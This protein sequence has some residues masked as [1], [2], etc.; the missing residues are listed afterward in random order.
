MKLVFVITLFFGIISIVKSEFAALVWENDSTCRSDTLEQILDLGLATQ[1]CSLITDEMTQAIGVSIQGFFKADCSSGSPSINLYSDPSCATPYPLMSS[2][3]LPTT[4]SGDQFGYFND[5]F[6]YFTCAD[7]S[8]FIVDVVTS[9]SKFY[10]GQFFN[11][12]D[13]APPTIL[14]SGWKKMRNCVKLHE[15]TTFYIIEKC[16]SENNTFTGALFNDSLCIHEVNQTMPLNYRTG[17]CTADGNSF[18]QSLIQQTGG[19]GLPLPF[20]FTAGGEVSR[21]V[22]CPPKKEDGNEHSGVSKVIFTSPI[23]ILG[24]I[25]LLCI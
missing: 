16:S 8:D 21:I 22:H 20:N 4:C 14:T 10:Y 7:K 15:N 18:D 11:S 19:S 13:C 3:P 24:L 17:E 5:G 23:L 9:D 25:F 1:T 2:V 6:G 12:S